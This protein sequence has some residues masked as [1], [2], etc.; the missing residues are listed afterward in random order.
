[1]S[2]RS[3]SAGKTFPSSA[4]SGFGAAPITGC[5]QLLSA[6]AASPDGA[7]IATGI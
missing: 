7:L 1:M 3:R 5:D 6:E 4:Q 2:I